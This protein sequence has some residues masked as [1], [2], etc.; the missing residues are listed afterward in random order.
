MKSSA[1]TALPDVPAAIEHLRRAIRAGDVLLI[2]GSRGLRLDR[3][4]N[5]LEAQ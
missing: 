2:K 5:A 4:V 3:L 1:I